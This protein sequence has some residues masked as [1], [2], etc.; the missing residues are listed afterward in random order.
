MSAY[1]ERHRDEYVERL[2]AV[3]DAEAWT[4]WCRSSSTA[5]PTRPQR[6]NKVIEGR[7]R[8]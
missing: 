7:S 1:F 5:S 6:T 2:R 3:S 4:E 8:R